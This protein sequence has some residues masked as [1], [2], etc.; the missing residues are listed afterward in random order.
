MGW[1]VRPG[2]VEHPMTSVCATTTT[3]RTD[4][5]DLVYRREARAAPAAAPATAAHGPPAAHAPAHHV[6]VPAGPHAEERRRAR[7]RLQCA[8]GRGGGAAV[9]GRGGG[10]GAGGSDGWEDEGLRGVLRG[11]AAAAG[12][13][14]CLLFGSGC[15]GRMDVWM[16]RGPL[17][18]LCRGFLHARV[19]PPPPQPSV[20][21]PL[22]LPLT[23]SERQHD[24]GCSVP[25]SAT[26]L[27]GRCH[28]GDDDGSCLGRGWEERGDGVSGVALAHARW[29]LGTTGTA[30]PAAD[31]LGRVRATTKKGL[32][33]RERYLG[34]RVEGWKK[35]MTRPR[36]K[37][38]GQQRE[39]ATRQY[40][41]AGAAFPGVGVR[42]FECR[43]NRCLASV[44]RPPFRSVAPADR[45]VD[46]KGCVVVRC[47]RLQPAASC[48]HVVP[49]SG[50]DDGPLGA[51]STALRA[52]PIEPTR[53]L[54]PSY[55]TFQLGMRQGRPSPSYAPETPAPKLPTCA[56]RPSSYH[57]PNPT[58]AH[59][60][61]PNHRGAGSSHVRDPGHLRVLPLGGGPPQGP[62][63]ERP[64][65]SFVPRCD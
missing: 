39:A 3:G 36:V 41:T 1:L 9:W 51:H 60:T 53:Q 30:K 38:N 6:V 45:S 57:L 31:C 17:R 22:A 42:A 26:A 8:S 28:P 2:R 11:E 64:Q 49:R 47:G 19:I 4:E 20:C 63:R 15:G 55:R 23:Q 62:H 33:R 18:P 65:V 16:V 56:P 54:A 40:T 46:S 59:A 34:G 29:W 44:D 12:Q 25:S 7:C 61:T 5:D 14:C 58:Y 35:S 50:S 48:M 24:G 21:R 43:D 13:P 27:G 32:G 37:T 52:P 10:G